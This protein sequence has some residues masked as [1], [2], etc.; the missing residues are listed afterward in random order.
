MCDKIRYD[1][2]IWYI[3][4]RSLVKSHCFIFWRSLYFSIIILN[5]P[6]LI[7]FI[8]FIYVVTR[9]FWVVLFFCFIFIHILVKRIWLRH[10]I[11]AFMNH[12]RAKSTISQD[13]YKWRL[14]KSSLFLL[15]IIIIM[16]FTKYHIQNTI[17]TFFVQIICPP[18]WYIFNTVILA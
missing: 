9:S 17:M 8:Y 10:Y 12:N 3:M 5:L 7:W 14:T 15:L 11:H 6:V 1:E 18:A 2:T 16:P 4:W 13:Y